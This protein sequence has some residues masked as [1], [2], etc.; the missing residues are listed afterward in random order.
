MKYC[1]GYFDKN[2][3]TDLEINNMFTEISSWRPPP[4]LSVNMV[5]LGFHQLK[6][7]EHQLLEVTNKVAVL[8]GGL[9][10]KDEGPKLDHLTY[11]REFASTPHLHTGAKPS[12]STRTDHEEGRHT[13]VDRPSKKSSEKNIPSRA[14]HMSKDGRQ[15]DTHTHTHTHTQRLHRRSSS[16]NRS[17]QL[18]VRALSLTGGGGLIAH[19]HATHST[20]TTIISM[21]VVTYL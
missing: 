4:Y 12:M 2:I 13:K 8:K 19:S 3:E 18:D 21:T 11:G 15:S 10:L 16:I 9:R 17:M 5:T 7:H 6:A 14:S 20:R 1:C